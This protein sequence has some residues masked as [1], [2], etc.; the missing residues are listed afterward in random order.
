MSELAKVEKKWI[1]SHNDYIGSLYARLCHIST[2]SRLGVNI[3]QQTKLFVMLSPHLYQN[4]NLAVK[5]SV[6]VNK[7]WPLGHGQ[8]RLSG[9]LGP[10]VPSVSDA[11]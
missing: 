7:N 3:P 4:K 6:N 10:L 1:P 5:C 11:K 8:Y 2:D 9:N